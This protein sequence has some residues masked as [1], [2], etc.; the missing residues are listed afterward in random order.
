LRTF[1]EPFCSAVPA[2]ASRR[3]S[4]AVR[5]GTDADAAERTKFH[6]CAVGSM[7]MDGVRG[8]ILKLLPAEY[9]RP[10]DGKGGCANCWPTGQ[11]LL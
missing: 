4:P 1:H 5:A 8:S 2:A 3:P 9:L 7:K 6:P 11:H 10:T